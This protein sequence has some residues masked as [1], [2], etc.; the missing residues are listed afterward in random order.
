[1]TEIKNFQEKVKIKQEIC[2]RLVKRTAFASEPIFLLLA[3]A[4]SVWTVFIKGISYGSECEVSK[5][6]IMVVALVL[7]LSGSFI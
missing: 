2:Y 6:R 7:T 3:C 5:F 4:A 1:M